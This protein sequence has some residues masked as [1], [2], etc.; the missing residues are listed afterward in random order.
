[1]RG[2]EKKTSPVA[3][4]LKEIVSQQRSQ[5]ELTLQLL[6]L[7]GLI[8]KRE[9]LYRQHCFF[10]QSKTSY[11]RVI[12]ASRKIFVYFNLSSAANYHLFSFSS[13]GNKKMMNL[14]TL[15]T[16]LLLAAYGCF[17]IYVPNNPNLC[18]NLMNLSRGL[19]LPKT[20]FY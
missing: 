16:N 9:S 1:M 3:K 18:P 10:G 12:L 11:K 7:L 8:E 13:K 6:N 14:K 17:V 20:G 5:L 19:N 2:K 15:G 4:Q